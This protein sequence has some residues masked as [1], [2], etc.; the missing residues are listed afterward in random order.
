MKNYFKLIQGDENDRA[1][2][3]DEPLT[4]QLSLK[5]HGTKSLGL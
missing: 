4:T 1:K 3:K 2:E 5:K